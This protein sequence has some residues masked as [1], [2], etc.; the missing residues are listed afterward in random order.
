MPWE[1][2]QSV[3]IVEHAKDWISGTTIHEAFVIL[4]DMTI[5]VGFLPLLYIFAALPVLRHRANGKN[6]GIAMIPGGRFACWL[7]SGLGFATTL[8]AIATSMVPPEGTA[9]PT[10]FLVKVVG[11]SVLLVGAG[12][13]F[14]FRGVG[15]AE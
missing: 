12:L 5:V 9:D 11:G 4:L 7:A 8:L 15:G 6:D 2:T 1:R 13:V 10:M 3:Q 14:Y